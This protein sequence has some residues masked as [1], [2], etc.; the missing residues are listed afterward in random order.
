VAFLRLED[1][2]STGE[3]SYTCSKWVVFHLTSTTTLGTLLRAEQR[4]PFT[5]L[6]QTRVFQEVAPRFRD[7]RYMNI[8]TAAFIPQE[9][10]LV[11]VSGR[12]WVDP[13]TIVRTEGLCHWKIYTIGNRTHDVPACGA[14]PEAIAPP[15]AHQYLTARLKKENYTPASLLD[16]HGLF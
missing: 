1:P 9:I 14:V 12:G 7:S 10:F 11:L 5:C 15:R 16:L 3:K 6:L 13:K 8:R 4:N 2:T